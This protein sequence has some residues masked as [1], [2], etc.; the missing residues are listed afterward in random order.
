MDQI[1][2]AKKKLTLI[3]FFFTI[4]GCASYQKKV[5]QSRNYMASGQPESAVQLLEPL[6]KE[7]GADQL[8]YLFDYATA[9]QAAGRYKESSD[10][11]ILADKMSDAKDYF[12]VSNFAGSLLLNEGVT[13]YKGEDYERLFINV[14]SA[15]NFVMSGERESAMVEIR[16]L[17]EKLDYFRLEQKK[18]YDKNTM[19]MY[20]SGILWESDNNWDSAYIDYERVYNR[21]PNSK[22]IKEDLVRAAIKARREDAA[23]KWMREFSIKPKPEWSNSKYGEIVLLYMQ[24]WGPRKAERPRVA[25]AFGFVS[26][27]FPKLVKVPADTTQVR[28]IAQGESGNTIIHQ[29][30]TGLIYSVE[31]AAIK[32]LEAQY[33]PLIAKRIA[34][35]VAKQQ[36][37]RQVGKNNEGL[38]AVMNLAL[39]LADT[40]D[41]RQWS[42]LPASFQ[43]ARLF[44][45]AG[46]YTL[47]LQGLTPSGTESNDK[48]TNIEIEV[49]PKKK[50][51]V[52]WRTY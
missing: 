42:T 50:S 35:Y 14:M 26:P 18:E 45:P 32:A 43:V 10:Q 51:F 13:Q 27:G 5:E 25:T 16:R 39:Q 15:F 34:A 7:P 49:K 22:Y 41:L 52:S 4:S 31:D 28:L 19:S 20:L 17:N 40:A 1:S 9:L 8:V 11:F 33:A 47:T 36:L 48:K 29:A 44:V 6:A 12:S 3:L 38:G 23:E 24:G 21:S 37:S 2:V 46:K 30:D